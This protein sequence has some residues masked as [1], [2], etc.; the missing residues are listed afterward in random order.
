M[1][2]GGA[3]TGGLYTDCVTVKLGDGRVIEQTIMPGTLQKLCIW[4]LDRQTQ[5][6]KQ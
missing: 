2:G 4:E 5:P 6:I 1:R 3:H